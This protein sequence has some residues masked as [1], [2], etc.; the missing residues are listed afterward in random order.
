MTSTARDRRGAIARAAAARKKPLRMPY[1]GRWAVERWTRHWHRGSGCGELT[2]G[3]ACVVHDPMS[4]A[5][6]Q[7]PL[8]PAPSR[9]ARR[10]L[11]S[12]Q[13][14]ARL[15]TT[16]RTL[17]SASGYT[18]SS[19]SGSRA[20]SGCVSLRLPQF[21]HHITDG[22]QGFD[23]FMNL[24][25]DNAV[26]VKQ[27]TKTNDK[28]SRRSLGTTFSFPLLDITTRD[29]TDWLT[30]C[31]ANSSQG[32]QRVAHPEPVVMGGGT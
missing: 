32:R 8:N 27:I 19:P 5:P 10:L 12:L 29:G 22:S 16:R 6:E 7:P 17:P 9:A 15:L 20:R 23:E 18:S 4:T 1:G 11:R 14:R 21:C 2:A 13:P 3:G 24:V 28:E 31:R 25:I 30:V 26:E